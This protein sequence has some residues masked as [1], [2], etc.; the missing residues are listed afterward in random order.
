MFKL[1]IQFS[2]YF[3]LGFCNI[4]S[5]WGKKNF[6]AANVNTVELYLGLQGWIRKEGWW[7]DATQFSVIF[8]LVKLARLQTRKT[9]P[10]LGSYWSYFV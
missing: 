1:S 2:Q 4:R 5:A 9:D 6:L 3:K 8:F 7:L 10:L